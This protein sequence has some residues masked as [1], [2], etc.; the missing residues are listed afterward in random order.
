MITGKMNSNKILQKNDFSTL[1]PHAG[2]MLLIDEVLNYSQETIVTRCV[3]HQNPDHPLRLN[4]KLSAL[5]LIEYG[6]Q[7]MAVHCGLL[8]GQA[9]SGFLAAVRAAHFYVEELE[10]VQNALIIHATAEA[11]LEKGAV[12]HFFIRDSQDNLLLEARATVVHLSS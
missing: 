10:A 8:S 3:S 6:A 4:G 1:V 9:H 7:T 11:Q 12:Y 5:H 2:S